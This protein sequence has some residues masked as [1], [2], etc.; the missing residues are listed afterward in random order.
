[1]CIDKFLGPDV[2]LLVYEGLYFLHENP[3]KFC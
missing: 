3:Y 2:I 1:M